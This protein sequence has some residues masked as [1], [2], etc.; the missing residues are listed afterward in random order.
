ML[1]INQKTFNTDVIES[2]LPVL[3]NFWA[4]WCGLCLML[5]PILTK[6]ESEWRG[7]IK[8]VTINADENFRLSNTY[9]L[10]SLPTLI[11]FEQGTI[12]HRFE[13]FNTREELYLNL[14]KIMFN[15]TAKTA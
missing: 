3:V 12:I 13:G 10:R 7:D 6:F 14:N 9:R 11:L 4:P 8:L 5:N 2:S 15:L 1:S